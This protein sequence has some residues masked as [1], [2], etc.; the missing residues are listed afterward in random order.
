[1]TY[2]V[3]MDNPYLKELDGKI[4]DKEFK[5]N[6]SFIQLDRTI[7]YPDLAGGQPMDYGSIN[8]LE[9]LNVY[10][11]GNS[12]IHVVKG[13]LTT[14]R[15]HMQIDWDRRFDMMQQHSGEHLLASSFYRLFNTN[16]LGIHIGNEFNTID[17]GKPY[18]TQ[19][20]AS[21]VEYLANKLIHSNFRVKAYTVSRDALSRIPLRRDSDIDDENIRIIEIDNI[22]YIACCGTHVSNTGEIG[23]IKIRRWEKYKGNIRVEFICGGRTLNDY[24]WKNIY[25]NEIGSLLSAKDSD[26]LDKVHQLYDAKEASDKENRYLREDLYKLKGQALLSEST[27]ENGVKYVIKEFHDKDS[28]EVN[29]ISSNLNKENQK[30]VQIY[31]IINQGKGQFIITRTKD[32][33][34]NL[35]KI[36]DNISKKIILKGG[37]SPQMVQGTSTPPIVKKTM[38][39][40]EKEIKENI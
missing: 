16:I 20:E 10:E 32:L 31:S 37:G 24:S 30:L 13:D 17:I 33:D 38:V 3:F 14:A 26:V 8:G 23:M 35:K 21:Q 40:F 11:E 4:I 7:F 19:E 28:K 1:M 18:L 2:K 15:V 9:V 36:F 39:M 5:D 29:L 22:D 6:K 12:I 34:I 27:E 25:I